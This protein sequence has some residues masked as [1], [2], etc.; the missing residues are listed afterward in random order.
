M[1]RHP[2]CRCCG[3]PLNEDELEDGDVCDECHDSMDRV[4]ANLSVTFGQFV[5]TVSPG[6][7]RLH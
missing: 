6:S 4:L 2:V 5:L 3:L 1:T 7:A